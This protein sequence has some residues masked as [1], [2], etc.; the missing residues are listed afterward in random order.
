MAT[1]G[2]LRLVLFCLAIPSLGKPDGGEDME[3]LLTCSVK[4]GTGHVRPT[5]DV[6]AWSHRLS[7][8][9]GLNVCF[10][11]VSVQSKA[12]TEE[13]QNRVASTTYACTMYMYFVRTRDSQTPFQ[14]ELRERRQRAKRAHTEK[15]LG[16][17]EGCLV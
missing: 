6:G 17:K 13:Q 5:C 15:E 3:P 8:E 12:T 14:A 4:K 1:S 10:F 7:R 2:P 9:S 11:C 16:V